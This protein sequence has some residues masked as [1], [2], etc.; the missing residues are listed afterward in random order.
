MTTS[1]ISFLNA[2]LTEKGIKHQF[3]FNIQ[4]IGFR[5]WVSPEH[6]FLEVRDPLNVFKFA[7]PWDKDPRRKW[8]DIHYDWIVYALSKKGSPI[9]RKFCEYYTAGEVMQ[10]LKYLDAGIQV[11]TPESI[12]YSSVITLEDLIAISDVRRQK[13][14]QHVEESKTKAVSAPK[15]AKQAKP[16]P[17]PSSA[18]SVPTPLLATPK[19][20]DYEFFDFGVNT[21]RGKLPDTRTARLYSSKGHSTVTLSSPIVKEIEERGLSHLRIRR[22]KLTGEH[23]FVFTKDTGLAIKKNGTSK[24]TIA[25]HNKELYDFLIQSFS[26]QSGDLLE[27]S[28][29]LANTKDFA[30]YKITKK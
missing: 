6:Y 2:F 3:R 11:R 5:S 23:Y 14:M 22:D 30:T 25:I 16:S 27:L 18:S 15:P 9:Y 28:P 12:K 24:S 4:D 13:I 21:N 29:N 7:F 8:A 20:D 17:A 10:L 1:E 19:E 26:C